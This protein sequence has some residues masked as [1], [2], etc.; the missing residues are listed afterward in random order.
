[1]LVKN[2]FVGINKISR[3]MVGV[4]VLWGKND[5]CLY[6]GRGQII[7]RFS[8]HLGSSEFWNRIFSITVYLGNSKRENSL[9]EYALIQ[10]YKPIF[11]KERRWNNIVGLKYKD[12]GE[13]FYLKKK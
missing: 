6:V 8:F 3:K 4:Y 1:M 12:W 11:N 9:L 5:E 7:N 2:D 13:R 10:R